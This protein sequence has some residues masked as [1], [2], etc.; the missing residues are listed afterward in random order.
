M[1]EVLGKDW[2]G[3]DAASPSI[4]FATLEGFEAGPKTY[5]QMCDVKEV[6]DEGSFKNH[7]FAVK[8]GDA[9]G[10][11]IFDPTMIRRVKGA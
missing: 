1:G 6:S 3:I 5:T 2:L 10:W 9:F 7:T 4:E 11:K 8:V